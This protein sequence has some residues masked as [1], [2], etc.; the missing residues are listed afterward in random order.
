MP[1]SG[2]GNVWRRTI[3]NRFVINEN[4][5]ATHLSLEAGR[6]PESARVRKG[7]PKIYL[8]KKFASVSESHSNGYT[9][10]KYPLRRQFGW[11]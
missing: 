2:N 8:W 6:Q 3:P 5:N 10:T 9:L 11:K 1:G 7:I 4:K